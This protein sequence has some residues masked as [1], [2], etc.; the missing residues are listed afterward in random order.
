MANCC[1]TEYTFL[2]EKENIIS[3]WTDIKNAFAS[4]DRLHHIKETLLPDVKEDFPSRGEIMYVDDEI[5]VHDDGKADFSLAT[6]TA[7]TA[8]NELMRAITKKYSVEMFYYSEEPGFEIFETNDKDGRYFSYRYVVDSS[9]DG[10][11]F[12]ETF[13]EVADVI[14]DLTGVKLKDISEA[15]EKLAPYNGLDTFLLIHEIEVV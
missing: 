5:F 4:N 10:I 15:E 9:V 8:C 13:D 12:Y 6:D 7:W 11:E 14:E 2:G 3:L 1:D